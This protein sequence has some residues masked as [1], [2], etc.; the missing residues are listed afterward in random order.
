MI[1]A[2]IGI[3]A[4]FSLQAS[5]AVK[6]KNAH[7]LK[8]ISGFRSD[9]SDVFNTACAIAI[10]FSQK[11]IAVVDQNSPGRPSVFRYSDIVAVEICRNGSSLIKTDRASQAVGAAVGAILL[12]PAGL[13]IGG[14]TAARTAEEE[15]RKLSIKIYTNDARS[16]VR[17]VVLFESSPAL[18]AEYVEQA[19]G[20]KL[21]EWYGRLRVIVE[22]SQE[23]VVEE[24][25]RDSTGKLR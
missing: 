16:P 23:S 13:L 9:A 1:L 22:R 7:S 10:D 2:I 14:L 20:S 18:S 5:K 8:R 15:V 4:I 6:D 3:G 17:E 21:D 12:G 24:E 11:K 19:Y 25:S